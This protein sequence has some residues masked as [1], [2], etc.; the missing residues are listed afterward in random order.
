MN[1]VKGSWQVEDVGRSH[2][3]LHAPS[4]HCPWGPHATAHARR[5]HRE[6]VHPSSQVHTRS[7]A[8]VPWP[9]QFEAHAVGVAQERPL[10]PGWQKQIPPTH[11][12]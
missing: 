4:K 5:S 12:P 1:R 10:Q 7:S 3:C 11:T 9:E 8:H 6:P 2:A